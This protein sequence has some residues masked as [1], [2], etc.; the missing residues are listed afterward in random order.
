MNIYF[1]KKN[2]NKYFPKFECA[3]N[4]LLIYDDDFGQNIKNLISKIE[5]NHKYK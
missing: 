5:S 1:L 4:I 3:K 2:L